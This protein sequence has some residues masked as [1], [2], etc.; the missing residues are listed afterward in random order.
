MLRDAF[1]L[2]YK[3]PENS[4]PVRQF[5]LKQALNLLRQ[6][7]VVEPF[8]AT[9]GEPEFDPTQPLVSN[10]IQFERVGTN[11]HR[12]RIN[13]DETVASLAGRSDCA[14]MTLTRIEKLHTS[15]RVSTIVSL[16]NALEVP[17]SFLFGEK[18]TSQN[19]DITAETVGKKLAEIVKSRGISEV[20]GRARVAP[21]TISRLIK[22]QTVCTEGTLVN[23]VEATG[24]LPSFFF[25]EPKRGTNP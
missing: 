19:P 6:A 5:A 9:L 13:R 3:M 25:N 12:L 8:R 10:Q 18:D 2:A 17:A 14:P 21:M 23:I 7:G 16:A 15:P 4:D 1:E 11:V 24:Q 20:A 22:G